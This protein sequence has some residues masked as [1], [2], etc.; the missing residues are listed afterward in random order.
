[1]ILLLLFASPPASEV[2]C[3]FSCSISCFSLHHQPQ[4]SFASSHAPSPAFRFT[5]SLRGRL[6]LL[7]LLLLLFASPPAS[8][9]VCFFSCSFSCFSLHH[10]P[11]RSFASSH[12]PSPAFRFTT[13]LEVVC[14]FSCSFSCFC[15]TTSLRGRLLL[16]MLLLLLF[17]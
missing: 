11:Q 15:F 4:R 10:Q 8:E 2:V 3:F 1:M 5:T 13:S 14:F 16:L 9:V 12:V 6:L 17:A 7:M